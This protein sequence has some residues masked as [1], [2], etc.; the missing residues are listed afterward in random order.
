MLIS[1]VHT[2]GGG[3]A[4]AADPTLRTLAAARG[5]RIGSAASDSALDQSQTYRDKLRYEFNSVTPENAMKWSRLEPA[6]GEY[7]W[8]QADAIVDFAGQHNQA[9]HGHT[10]VWHRSVP[11][12]VTE[13]SFTDAQL[14]DILRRHIQT[15][16]GRYAGRVDSW[17]VVNEAFAA[18]G[19][20]RPSIW[21]ERLG[22]GYIADAFHW[23][24]AA[25]PQAK[26]YINDYEIEYDTP[27]REALH[28]LVRDLRAQG[29]PIDGVGFQT[30]VPLHSE[31]RQLP[32]TLRMFADLGVDVAITE[33][34]VRM[35]L[36]VDS[37]KLARQAELYRRATA[38]CLAVSRCV[39]LTVWGFTDAHSW[40]PSTLPGWGAAT[41]LDE[42]YGEKPA[43]AQVHATL[44]DRNFT[45]S[46]KV[47]HSLRCLEVPNANDGVALRQWGCWD[48]VNQQFEFRRVAPRTYAVASVR[49]G[50]CLTVAGG[51]TANGAAIVQTTCDDR[52]GQRF[53]LRKVAAVGSDQHFR[54]VATHSGRCLHVAAAA[55]GNGAAVTQQSCGTGDYQT[56]RL[57]GAPGHL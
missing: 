37:T 52:A 13:G 46:A 39:S 30:H 41:L 10:L 33:L 20:L 28:E 3:A 26:L 56:W 9:V 16:V 42:Q 31:L 21:L 34:D 57:E 49:S 23:A 53:E 19:S 29:V 7:H 32:D 17:D 47:L 8:E 35:Q 40:V 2:V 1:I 38:A 48:T 12:W 14:R 25:D 11:A 18:D 36:P 51:S 43:Y 22:P 45:G 55:L 24:R 4:G 50:T 6:Q 44:A 15:T 27:K 54:V 5:L